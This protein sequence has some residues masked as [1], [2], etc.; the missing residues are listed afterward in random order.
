M[1]TKTSFGSIFLES[2]SILFIAISVE[3]EMAS[4][5]ALYNMSFNIFTIILKQ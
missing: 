4:I 3:D 5:L 1:A 2:N